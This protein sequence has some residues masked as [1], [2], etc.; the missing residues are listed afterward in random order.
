MNLRLNC[1]DSSS[2]NTTSTYD[3]IR[4]LPKGSMIF[5]KLDN[6]FDCPLEKLNIVSNRIQRFILKYSIEYKNLKNKEKNCNN[7]IFTEYDEQLR[8]NDYYITFCVNEQEA[9]YFYKNIFDSYIVCGLS[10]ESY[11]SNI[12]DVSKPAPNRNSMCFCTMV[13]GHDN[14]ITASALFIKSFKKYFP[15]YK[16]YVLTDTETYPKLSTLYSK[17]GFTDICFRFINEIKV[18]YDKSTSTY[19]WVK[20]YNKLNVFKLAR[21]GYR[22]V[23]M[24]D[25]G[26]IITENFVY[27]FKYIQDIIRLMK[28]PT[29]V[30]M[31][32]Y[33]IEQIATF[34]ETCPIYE[35]AGGFYCFDISKDLSKDIIDFANKTMTQTGEEYLVQEYYKKYGNFY[36]DD[37]FSV[38]GGLVNIVESPTESNIDFDDNYAE[39]GYP[40]PRKYLVEMKQSW[41]IIVPLLKSIKKAF[42]TNTITNSFVKKLDKTYNKLAKVLNTTKWDYPLYH[43]LYGF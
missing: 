29:S 35:G 37:F 12:V 25:C 3:S 2:L 16:M 27:S 38:K 14:Y 31:G 10:I 39:V 6:Y 18:N 9:A 43:K 8:K 23:A 5:V 34:S 40:L 19:G 41:N 32:R 30:I 36:A 22:Y 21:E 15:S 1:T 20:T 24:F 42:T 26:N 7:I 28:E 4:K 33:T 13:L 17:L 11:Y